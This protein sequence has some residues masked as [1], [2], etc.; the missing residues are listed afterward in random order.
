MHSWSDGILSVSDG[1]NFNHIDAFVDID[2]H[3]SG[4]SWLV[5]VRND[6]NDTK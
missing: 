2:L 5:D 1:L 3:K 6:E 4:G